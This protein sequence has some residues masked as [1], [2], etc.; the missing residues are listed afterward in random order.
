MMARTTTI[1]FVRIV[2]VCVRIGELCV[3]G[4]VAAPFHLLLLYPRERSIDPRRHLAWTN[5]ACTHSHIARAQDDRDRAAF[6]HLHSC[7]WI[8]RTVAQEFLTSPCPLPPVPGTRYY[9]GYLVRVPNPS[10]I[11]I[12]SR[13]HPYDHTWYPGTQFS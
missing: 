12:F 5:A 6:A 11:P 3:V 1:S 13:V 8:S 2:E 9:T 7:E 10:V 4:T